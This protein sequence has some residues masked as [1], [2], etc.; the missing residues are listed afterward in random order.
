M[1]TRILL[2]VGGVGKTTADNLYSNVY[3]F[4]KHTLDY[5]WGRAGFE[6]LTNEQFKG[7][8]NRKENLNWIERYIDDFCKIVDSGTY[9]VV[10]S[11]LLKELVDALIQRGYLVEVILFDFNS[12]LYLDEMKHTLVSMGNNQHHVQTTLNSY[13]NNIERFTSY[14]NSRNFR[15]W[16][17]DKPIYLSEFLSNTGTVLKRKGV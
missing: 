14:R 6:H 5:K 9:D 4:D 8:P 10:T 1:C 17:F 11:Y 15:K 3:D 2:T 7:L 12:D 16:V 13:K